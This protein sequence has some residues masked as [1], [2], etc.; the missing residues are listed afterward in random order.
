MGNSNIVNGDGNMTNAGDNIQ[1]IINNV[2]S[3][4]NLVNSL[5]IQIDD[6]K[7]DSQTKY[8]ELKIKIDEFKSQCEK[9]KTELQTQFNDLKTQIDDQITELNKCKFSKLKLKNNWFL[10]GFVIILLGAILFSQI[11]YFKIKDNYVGLVLGFVGILATFIV[12]SNYA[13]VKEIERKFESKVKE[14]KN[15]LTTRII[16]ESNKYKIITRAM[17]EHELGRSS[18]AGDGKL[19]FYMRSLETLNS[20][21]E[22]DIADIVIGS[23]SVLKSMDEA[24][25]DDKEKR[26]QLSR[27]N[28]I[29]YAK[30]LDESRHKLC[31]ELIKWINNAPDSMIGNM[32]EEMEMEAGDPEEYAKRHSETTANDK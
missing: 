28:K 17:S 14:I 11:E 24:R 4:L 20:V 31:G 22:Y 6:L 9:C 18:S 16:D 15:S 21:R 19:L 8:D 13:Q 12:V 30:I 32:I 5:S 29:K 27:G 1:Q 3:T 23:I 2:E 26:I 10:W 7:K 25:G